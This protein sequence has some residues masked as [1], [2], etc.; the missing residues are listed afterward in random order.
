[1]NVSISKKNWL[2]FAPSGAIGS[3]LILIYSIWSDNG[4]A[5]NRGQ[6]IIWTNDDLAADA[7]MC[8]SAS[9]G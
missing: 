4:L 6:A 8:H 9:M 7:Y 5:P 1:M 2:Q 3:R